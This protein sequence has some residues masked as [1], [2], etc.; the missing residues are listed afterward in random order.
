[1]KVKTHSHT[2]F[3]QTNS[4]FFKKNLTKEEKKEIYI[5]IY[6]GVYVTIEIIDRRDCSIDSSRN[7]NVN[8]EKRNCSVFVWLFQERRKQERKKMIINQPGTHEKQ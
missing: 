1:M 4:L 5:Y 7:R 8:E 2:I 6:I 3:T